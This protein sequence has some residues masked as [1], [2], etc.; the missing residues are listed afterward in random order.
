MSRFVAVASLTF[1]VVA[2]C[3]K[4]SA[5]PPFV[6]GA[7]TTPVVLPITPRE[8]A[9]E[10]PPEGWCGET[11]IQEGLL[12]LG[13]WAPQRLINKVGKPAHPDLYSTDIPVALTDLGVRYTFY[14]GGRGFD[15][16]AAW[17]RAAIDAGDPVLAGVKILPTKHPEWGLDHFVLVVGYGKDAGNAGGD[18]LLVNT[19]WGHREWVA[20]TNTPGLSFAKAGYAIRMSGL[21]MTPNAR[22]ARLVV[23]EENDARVR[24]HVVC[25]GLEKGASYTIERRGSRADPKPSWSEDATAAGDRIERDVTVEADRASRFQCVPRR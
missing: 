22:A 16:F 7:P 25:T 12:H 21:A 6:L 24:V 2:A 13:V 1:F 4:A 3:G 17:I 9:R 8:H 15:A 20:D 23:L 14:P 10:A 11:A 5:A 18:R 19:T